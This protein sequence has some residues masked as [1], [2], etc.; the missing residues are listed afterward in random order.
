MASVGM[1]NALAANPNYYL[2]KPNIDRVEI[3]NYPSFRSAW[4][5]MLRGRNDML[6]EVGVEAL[7][8]LQGATGTAR[9]F[10]FPKRYQYLIVFNTQSAALQSPQVRRALNLSVDRAALIRDALGGH[11]QPSVGPVSA[12]YWALAGADMPRL[13]FDP[14]AAASVIHQNRPGLRFTCLVVPDHERIALVVKRQL[15]A[16]GVDMALE[17]VRAD[18]L[19]KRVAARNFD[20]LLGDAVSGPT[21]YRLYRFWH[22]GQTLNPVGTAL[23]SVDKALDDVRRSASDEEYRRA[24]AAFVRTMLE[25]PPAIFLAWSEGAR[26]I[27]TRFVVPT[28]PERPDPIATLRLWQPAN[29]QLAS[30]RN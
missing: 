11:G 10:T 22:S 9:V 26:A 27:S 18:E 16:V 8:S 30:S 17:E 5:D 25:D 4:A 19:G 20:A 13:S 2:G 21:M 14:A 23:P 12:Q 24:V 15:E 6:Y 29:A 28:D 1:S 7:D 3:E